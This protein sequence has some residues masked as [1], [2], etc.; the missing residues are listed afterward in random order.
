[1]AYWF[2]N[3]GMSYTQERQENFLYAP[4]DNIK[5]HRNVKNVKSGDIILCNKN[6]YIL[7]IARALSDGYESPIPDSIK[8]LWDATGYKVD[9]EY[10]DLKEKFRFIYGC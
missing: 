2:V 7:S 10:I 8:G 1:M 5:H 9:V 3:Q 4:K 6:G